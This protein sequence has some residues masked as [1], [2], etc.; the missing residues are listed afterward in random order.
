MAITRIKD[1]RLEFNTADFGSLPTDLVIDFEARN[2]DT[3]ERF[4]WDGTIWDTRLPPTFTNVKFVNSASDF[5]DAIAGVRE[6]VPTPGDAITYFISAINIDVGSDRFT[7]TGGDVVILGLHRTASTI[8]TTNSGTMFTCVDS[9]FFPE[10]VGF[11]CPNAKVIDFSTPVEL[12]K[13]IVLDNVIIRD[14]DTCGDIDGAFT[15]SFRTVTVVTC[16][17]R[18]FLWTGTDSSQINISDFLGLSWAGTLLDL[19]TAEFDIISIGTDCRFISPGGATILSGAAGSAN[20]RAAGRALVNANL[21]NGTGTAISGIDTMDLQ[22]EFRGNTFADGTTL[23]SR[24]LVDG[25]LTASETVTISSTGVYVPIGGS[26]WA[27][28][29]NDR[30]TVSTGGLVTYIGLRN[31]EVE[32]MAFS[33]VEKV[34]GGS[35]KI[36]SKVAINGVVSDKTVGCTQNTTPTGITSVGLFTLSTGDTMQLFVANEDSTADIIVSESTGIIKGG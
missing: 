15:S 10:K 7:I 19:G 14:C 16:T 8:T 36:C 34:G 32:V 30:F 12:L 18:G 11:D 26:N 28:D 6:L 33:T 35:D 13:S 21:F 5:P 24:Q 22:W 27:T 2:L 20:L 31:I 1:E 23:N 17:T 25:F 29:I 3:D 4:V 9:G